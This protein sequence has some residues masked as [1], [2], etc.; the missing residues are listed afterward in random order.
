MAKSRA[1]LLFVGEGLELEDDP[2]AEEPEGPV[3]VG[4]PKPVIE[5]LKGPGG[6]EAEAP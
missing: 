2:V 4:T 1:V 5:P 6:A 3:A